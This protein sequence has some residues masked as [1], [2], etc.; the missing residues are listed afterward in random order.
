MINKFQ[1]TPKFDELYENLMEDFSQQGKGMLANRGGGGS[2]TPQNTVGPTT[3]AKPATSQ[4]AAPVVNI[5][6]KTA[7]KPANGQQPDFGQLL[8]EPDDNKA[9]ESVINHLTTNKINFNDPNFAKTP[10]GQAIGQRISKNPKFVDAL[11]N[12]QTKFAQTATANTQK[13]FANQPQM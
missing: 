11:N 9:A 3:Q 6:G 1:M 2:T 4:T 5:S 13:A 7:Q 8:N 12:A 10:E